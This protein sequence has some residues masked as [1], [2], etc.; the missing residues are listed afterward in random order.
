MEGKKELKGMWGNL[1]A[2]ILL[3]ITI[4]LQDDPLAYIHRAKASMDRKKLSLEPN[5]VFLVLKLII[6]LFGTK[7]NLLFILLAQS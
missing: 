4:S 5:I 3:P 7:V 2:I 1:V 6:Y